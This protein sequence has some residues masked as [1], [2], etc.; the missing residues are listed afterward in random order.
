MT[1]KNSKKK[2]WFSKVFQYENIIY[3]IA[4]LFWKGQMTAIQLFGKLEVTK[5][6]KSTV[7]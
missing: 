5:G 2:N 6:E 7:K 3:I 4:G 1:K